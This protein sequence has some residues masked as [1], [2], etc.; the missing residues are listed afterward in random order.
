MNFVS[1][2]S[3]NSNP[4]IFFLTADFFALQT[5]N[6]FINLVITLPPPLVVP[7]SHTP[8]NQLIKATINPMMST[9]G[10]GMGLSS[11]GFGNNLQDRRSIRWYVISLLCEGK[12]A[13]LLIVGMLSSYRT[14]H[15][16][17]ELLPTSTLP[18]T[19]FYAWNP[20][21]R[22]SA[23]YPDL[24]VRLSGEETI[25]GSIRRSGDPQGSLLDWPRRMQQ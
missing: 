21:T 18:R 13:S 9:S 17:M 10:D 7:S 19:Y 1:L 12:W 16:A 6:V 4:Y 11:K 5:P 22:D 3:R 23:L 25:S 8:G 20:I 14:R 24:V 15:E 2:R